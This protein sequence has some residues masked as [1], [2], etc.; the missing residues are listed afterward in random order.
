V[1]HNLSVDAVVSSTVFGAIFRHCK[2]RQNQQ[3]YQQQIH[4]PPRCYFAVS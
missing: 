2:Q 1:L 3:Q 4:E